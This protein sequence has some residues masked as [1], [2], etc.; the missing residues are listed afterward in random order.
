MFSLVVSV[1][2]FQDNLGTYSLFSSLAGLFW[3]EITCPVDGKINWVQFRP[4]HPHIT[5]VISKV[6]AIH[7]NHVTDWNKNGKHILTAPVERQ[8]SF[9]HSRL[10]A[11]L[12][13]VNVHPNE[14]KRR[15]YIWWQGL[16]VAL[17]LPSLED[18]ISRNSS[19]RRGLCDYP[20]K[21]T[22]IWNM[23][24]FCIK[25]ELKSNNSLSFPGTNCSP[26]TLAAGP[27]FTTC[28]M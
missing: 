15:Q 14:I 3:S 26:L 7:D 11:D 8:L 9:H 22:T 28:L 13:P 12:L 17:N 10:K 23:V 4:Y 19:S 1:G 24:Q 18:L 27:S 25:L 16:C 21:L 5:I 6:N 20:L 2:L